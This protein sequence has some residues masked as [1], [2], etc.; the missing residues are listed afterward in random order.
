MPLFL[1]PEF[2]TNKISRRVLILIA[3]PAISSADERELRVLTEVIKEI[4]V[5]YLAVVS[6]ISMFL[7]HLLK[8][9]V[10]AASL[11]LSELSNRNSGGR[12]PFLHYPYHLRPG[13]Y[14]FAVCSQLFSLK[15]SIEE[16]HHVA[17]QT[18]STHEHQCDGN[19]S[20]VS[21]AP[22]IKLP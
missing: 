8:L 7:P 6:L 2:N 14:A 19:N 13:T 9:S 11:P 20:S 4:N 5:N 22:Y 16:L 12:T 21:A 1:L 18:T 3:S 17:P 10:S 15:G